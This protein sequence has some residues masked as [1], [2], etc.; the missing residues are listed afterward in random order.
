M[1]AR[2]LAA[3][4]SLTAGLAAVV[5]AVWLAVDSFPRGVS[6]L[7]VLVVALVAAWYGIRRRGTIRL[8]GLVVAALALLLAVVLVLVEGQALANLAVL[9]LFLLALGL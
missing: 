8:L 9:V 4:G 2:R 3:A 1:S 7:A 6:V 5:F